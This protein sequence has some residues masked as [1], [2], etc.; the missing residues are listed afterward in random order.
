[1]NT[2]VHG[3]HHFTLRC[4]LE[5]LDAL[6]DFYR[7]AL[8]LEPGDRPALRF[9]GYWLYACGQPVVHLYASGRAA[10]PEAVALDH[11]SFRASG[12]AAARRRLAAEGIDYTEA[13][14]PGWSLHQVFIRDPLGLKLELTFDMAEEGEGRP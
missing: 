4:E 10:S 2:I 14:V 11:V 12:L 7:R 6:S 8:G 9:P 3:L 1:M 5:Q 13:P